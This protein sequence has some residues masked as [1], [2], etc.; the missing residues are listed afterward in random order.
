MKKYR[1]VFIF[2]ILTETALHA[3]VIKVFPNFLI[4]TDAGLGLASN[5]SNKNKTKNSNSHF[6]DGNNSHDGFNFHGRITFALDP[7]F[8]VDDEKIK[9]F[10]FRFTPQLKAD[11]S[12]DINN[13]FTT[14]LGFHMG[15]AEAKA[16]YN[17]DDNK[18]H[19]LIAAKPEM[20][21]YFSD[22]LGLDIAP[23]LEFDVFESEMYFGAELGLVFNPTRKHRNN[24]IREQERIKNEVLTERLIENKKKDE[25]EAEA[26]Q[27]RYALANKIIIKK[28]GFV[29]EG[30]YFDWKSRCSQSNLYRSL[31][32]EYATP[33]AVGDIFAVD[34]YMLTIKHLDY[35]NG[36]YSYLIS[37]PGM[38]KCCNIFSLHQLEY[39]DEYS[40]LIS[41]PMLIRFVGRGQ[42]RQG[43]SVV[44]CD[45]FGLVE[46]NTTDYNN[47]VK[48]M[49]DIYEIENNPD[50]YKDILND[51][52]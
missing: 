47:Y 26:K 45:T 37:V 17:A 42:Y 25:Q 29:S 24:F 12:Y 21:F 35:V 34:A 10:E 32:M 46:K 51:G 20:N 23:F 27:R 33:F 5:L 52:E 16:V 9:K 41:E 50:L 2:F 40:G 31:T 30:N 1:L 48:M 49:K 18:F 44:D 6:I 15:C 39:V 13:V 22:V 43:Y 36:A 4:K 11:C 3:K 19:F 7:F 8:I 14:S 38:S 28:Y